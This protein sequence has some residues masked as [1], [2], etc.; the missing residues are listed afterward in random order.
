MQSNIK[1]KCENKRL[2]AGCGN[3]CIYSFDFETNKLIVILFSYL[4]TLTLIFLCKN[5][6]NKYEA[7]SDSIYQIV[8]KN[9]QNELVSC[10]EDG[11]IKSWGYY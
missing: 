1:K 11:E 8:M 3:G 4:Y 2:F 5:K 7:H 10:S 6:K 9:T